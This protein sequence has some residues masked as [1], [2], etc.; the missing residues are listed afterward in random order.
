MALR[1]TF[2]DPATPVLIVCVFLLSSVAWG[3]QSGLYCSG[4]M[5]LGLWFGHF[6]RKHL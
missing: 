6:L 1:E 5:F 3:P 4:L 2:R